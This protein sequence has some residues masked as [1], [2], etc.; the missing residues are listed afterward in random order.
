MSFTRNA[1]QARGEEG[2]LFSQARAG[3]VVKCP[4]YARGGGAGGK[5]EMLK[6]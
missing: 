4:G 2:Q 5:E 3:K 1:T 6:L